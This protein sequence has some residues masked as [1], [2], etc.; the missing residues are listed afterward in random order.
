M[1][2]DDASAADDYAREEDEESQIKE[3][4]ARATAQAEAARQQAV[5]QPTIGRAGGGG[6]YR[7]TRQGGWGGA[8][9]ACGSGEHGTSQGWRV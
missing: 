8:M 2:N 7:W 3:M 4:M 9:A 5:M 1:A 6:C